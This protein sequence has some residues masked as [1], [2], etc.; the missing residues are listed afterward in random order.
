MK[1]CCVEEIKEIGRKG[2]L[3]KNKALIIRQYSSNVITWKK[4]AKITVEF[5]SFK[6]SV[7]SFLLVSRVN[8]Q[9]YKS[10]LAKTTS[11]TPLFLL[12]SR[13]GGRTVKTTGLYSRNDCVLFSVLITSDIPQ[14][15]SIKREYYQAPIKLI[16]SSLPSAV[17]AK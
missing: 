16:T 12:N 10:R 5:S 3:D 14:F 8:D 17:Y 2:K 1:R 6:E 7:R 11:S 4:L 13:Y 15:S 9:F